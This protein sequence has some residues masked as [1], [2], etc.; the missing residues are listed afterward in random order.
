MEFTSTIVCIYKQSRKQYTSWSAGF[1]IQL[2]RIYTVFQ[3][4]YTQVQHGM[5]QMIYIILHYLLV[6]IFL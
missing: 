4:G 2:I 5:G 1:R 6:F 3:T